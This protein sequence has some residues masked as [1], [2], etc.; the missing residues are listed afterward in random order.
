MKNIP[1]PISHNAA[2]YPHRP[3]LTS[4][5]RIISYEELNHIVDAT[6]VRLQERGIAPGDVVA[7]LSWNTIEYTILFFAAFRLGFILMPLNC[8]LTPTD[9]DDQIMRAEATLLACGEEFK[10]ISGLPVPSIELKALIAPQANKT[11]IEKSEN[12]S[13]DREALIM[14]SSGSTGAPRGVVL[15]WGNLYYSALG[16]LSVMPFGENDCWPATLPFFHIGG[17]SIPLRTALAGGSTRIMPGFEPDEIIKAAATGDISHLSVVPT[18]LVELMRV[19]TQNILA[20]MKA[21]ILGGARIEKSLLE[22]VERRKL[23]VLTTYGLTETAS[24]VTLL[25]PQDRPAGLATAGKTLPYRELKIDVESGRIVVR[26][27]TLFARYLDEMESTGLSRREWLT[28]E[29]IGSLTEDGILTV[30]GRHDE[31]IISGGENISPATIEEALCRIEEVEAA[32]V[33]SQPDTKWGY[34]PVA[35]VQSSG[36]SLT[37]AGILEM[38]RRR[39]ASIMIP[40]RVI[41]IESI[42]LTGSG[43]Y[44]RPALWR[45]LAEIL[46][47]SD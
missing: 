30:L 12:Y 11:E 21:I 7:A 34:R 39:L 43:K 41:I 35:F 32:V 47:E 25:S 42:P 19:D 8:R 16:L 23:P 5:S 20:G 2:D 10:D 17:I 45:Q 37:E 9:W 33:L 40:D 38:L 3:A 31:M 46:G 4:R 27:E 29:D 26:G 24:M 6:V 44:D 18:M 36:D 13:L 22:E 28:T 15:T 14:F 1:C